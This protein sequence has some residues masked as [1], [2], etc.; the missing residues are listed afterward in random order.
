MTLKLYVDRMSQACREVIIFCKLNGI[1]FE[2]VHIDLSKRQQLSPEYR[3]INPIRQIPAIMDG[4]FKLSE[5][6][7]ILRYLACA[8][9]RIADH[10]YPADLYKRAKVESVLDWQRTTFPR[11]PG[12][13]V[14]YSVLGTT[15]GMPLNT[16]AAARTEKNLIASL[17]LIESVWLQKKGRF[18]LGSDQPSIADLSL[19][20]EIMELEVLDDKDHERILGPFKRVLKWLDDT[21]NAMAPHFEE[22]Q[23]TLSNYKEK[24]QKQR[25]A[26]G[27]KITQSGR[28][29][30]LQSKM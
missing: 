13:Y 2:E 28:K 30:V 14:F 20:C 9:P 26:V 12:S 24:V 25:N 5:S 16:K 17:A 22:V 1:N 11:G 3:E 6:H 10:W 18:L 8:F 4:R 27:S 15:V 29:P 7:A 23:S 19:A 21:K